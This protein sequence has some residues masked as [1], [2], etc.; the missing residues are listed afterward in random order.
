MRKFILA[1]LLLGASHLSAQVTLDTFDLGSS[2]GSVNTSTSWNNNVTTSSTFITV[3]GTANDDSG[4][5]VANLT[6]NGSAYSYVAITAR[7]ESGNAASLLKV[8]FEDDAFEALTVQVA[9]SSFT[10]GAFT[11]VYIPVTWTSPF[12]AS[13]ISGWNIGGGAASPGL[14]A[15]RMSFENLSLSATNGTP[16]PEPSTYAAIFGA[17]ALG[18]VAYRRRQARA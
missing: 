17:L 12:N 16:I 4:W 11:T 1:A 14:A 8:T 5:S 9:T 7:L 6:L 15:F 2:T 13:A 10:T 3:G 18:F